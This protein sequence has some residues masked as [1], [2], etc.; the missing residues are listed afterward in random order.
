MIQSI[1][2]PFATILVAEF[3]DKSQLSILLLATKT[4]RHLALLLGV[5]LAFVVVDGTA[6]LFG[7]VLTTLIPHTMLKVISGGLFLLFGFLSLRQSDEDE[8]KPKIMANPL[9]TGFLIVFLSE[10][11]DK[12]Q[13]ASTV[14]ATQYKPFFVFVGVLSALF[15]LS[16]IAV[17]FSKV[18]L[19]YIHVR[20]IRQISGILFILLGIFFL[21]V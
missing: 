21:F 9:F 10:W 20:N 13:I 8:T 15:L 2:I 14:F 3:L 4:K 12:T 19:H 6:I 17:T 1:L 11:G 18:L 5:C 7:S 16:I